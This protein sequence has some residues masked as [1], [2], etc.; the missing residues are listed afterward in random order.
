MHAPH[1]Y[2]PTRE[3]VEANLNAL[4]GPPMDNR[5]GFWVGA[6][7]ILLLAVSLLPVL[8]L[9]LWRAVRHDRVAMAP[10]WL[11]LCVLMSIHGCYRVVA[12]FTPSQ[13]FRYTSL[14]L[15][16]AVVLALHG[17]DHLPRWLKRTVWAIMGVLCALCGH[18]IVALLS[19]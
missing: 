16:P 7:L 4:F 5:T 12:P 11:T 13:D 1:N 9:G 17:A 3:Q 15:L 8:G 10:M 2:W 14:V 18:F 19:A 6:L